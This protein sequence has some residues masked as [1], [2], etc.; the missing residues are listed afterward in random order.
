MPK[1][2]AL[3]ILAVIVVVSGGIFWT[4]QTRPGAQPTTVNTYV[5][6]TP[7]TLDTTPS[8]AAVNTSSPT[9]EAPLP[10]I[11]APTDAP[12]EPA[13]VRPMENFFERITKKPFGIYITPQTSPIQPEKFTGYHT[14]ADAETT[15][16][17][18]DANLPVM[19]VTKGTVVFAGHVN[20]YGG[21]IIIRH[22]ID[23]QTVTGLYGHLRISSFKV[24]KNDG[25]RVGQPIAV[26]GTGYSSE[27]DGE[28]KHLHFGLIKGATISYRGYV[29]SKNQLSA[30]EDPVAWLKRHGA[31]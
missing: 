25:V 19:A 12:A 24:G 9:V 26:L 5:T 17:E 18:K 29:S 27:T 2:I 10:S 11:V 20:G 13:A 16:A 31:S 22:T 15:A 28:R 8:D 30:W 14:G 21:V 1:N 6:N 7:N 3:A 4:V 23:G